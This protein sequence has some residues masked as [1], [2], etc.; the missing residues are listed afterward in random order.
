MFPFCF[1]KII[2]F[3]LRNLKF[4]RMR[5]YAVIG[6]TLEKCM[7]FQFSRCGLATL[8]TQP[9][10]LSMGLG[11]SQILRCSRHPVTL[12]RGRSIIPPKKIDIGKIYRQ[13]SILPKIYRLQQVSCQFFPAAKENIPP[14]LKIMPPLFE[15][16]HLWDDKSQH[17]SEMGSYHLKDVSTHSESFLQC[18]K[19]ICWKALYQSLC[20]V[21]LC[22]KLEKNYINIFFNLKIWINLIKYLL[23]GGILLTGG[24]KWAGYFRWDIYASIF[25][26]GIFFLA[27][28]FLGAG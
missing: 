21:F 7:H 26:C 13:E 6:C 15:L 8:S 17:I 1:V 3:Y 10:F 14:P 20:K 5:F 9:T 18:L 16:R 25:S 2:H 12:F 23:R 22:Q 11:R 19:Y 28:Y 24:K 27:V 4:F